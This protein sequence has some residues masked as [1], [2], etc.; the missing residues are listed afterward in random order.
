MTI[1]E[2]IEALTQTVELLASF[3]AD[4]E[5]RRE[6]DEKRM[7]AHEKRMEEFGAEHRDFERR[8]TEY[9]ADV[10]DAIRRLANIAGAHN[11]T[12]EDHEHRLD[13]LES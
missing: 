5:K 8:M 2:R 4:S 10:K 3:H 7:E 13:D 1:D 12:L 11:E 9:A 6:A